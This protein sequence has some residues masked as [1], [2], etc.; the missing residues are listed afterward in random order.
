MTFQVCAYTVCT[1]SMR[2][3]VTLGRMNCWQSS[4]MMGDL[5]LQRFAGRYGGGATRRGHR[6]LRGCLRSRR[7]LVPGLDRRRVVAD[8]RGVQEEA[9]AGKCGRPRIDG[10]ASTS[11]SRERRRQ[12][13]GEK[14]W[15]SLDERRKKCNKLLNFP[16]SLA[17]FSPPPS[18]LARGSQWLISGRKW[19][20]SRSSSSSSARREGS[21]A[22]MPPLLSG[23]SDAR[24]KALPRDVRWKGKEEPYPLLYA[25]ENWVEED[26]SHFQIKNFPI[27]LL[28][29]GRERRRRRSWSRRR[30]AS[31]STPSDS[32]LSRPRHLISKLLRPFPLPAVV[33]GVPAAVQP[34]LRRSAFH[35]RARQIWGLLARGVHLAAKPVLCLRAGTATS[36]CFPACQ[37]SAMHKPLPF[38]PFGRPDRPFNYS[39]GGETPASLTFSI[40]LSFR[41]VRRLFSLRRTCPT[42]ALARPE[43]HPITVKSM[44]HPRG[45]EEGEVRSLLVR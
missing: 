8:G 26:L 15:P 36:C 45:G 41:D 13:A 35:P 4:E 1:Y 22:K 31:R 39:I 19:P 32:S 11:S 30:A 2:R 28:S 18:T 5:K 33:G 6:G 43:S 23:D 10:E 20:H 38:P 42:C 9:A 44:G 37:P 29:T 12:R 27:Y 25:P 7:S 21:G 34:R 16:L 17:F 14:S 3:N 24:A 40:F